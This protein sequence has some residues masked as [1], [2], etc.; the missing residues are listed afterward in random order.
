MQFGFWFFSEKDDNTELVNES[1]FDNDSQ[2]FAGRWLAENVGHVCHSFLSLSMV[3]LSRPNGRAAPRMQ[4]WSR[5]KQPIVPGTLK[6]CDLPATGLDSSTSAL[7]EGSRAMLTGKNPSEAC[8]YAVCLFIMLHIAA[9]SLI[10]AVIFQNSFSTSTD[11]TYNV[12]SSMLINVNCIFFCVCV[13]SHIYSGLRVDDTHWYRS[14]ECPSEKTVTNCYWFY[15]E[16]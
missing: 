2:R 7:S 14:R 9:Q 12:L 15:G 5:K 16:S 3:E 13:V 4:Q 8:R 6:K 11:S 1:D 10:Y